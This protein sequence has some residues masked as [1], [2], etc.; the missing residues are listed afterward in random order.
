M[1]NRLPALQAEAAELHRDVRRLA[2]AQAE[3]ALAAG[4]ALVEAKALC[5]HGAWRGWLAEAGIP[6]RSARRYMRLHQA[7]LK[8][9]TVADL[10]GIRAADRF[11]AQH[12][13]PGVGME[14]LARAWMKITGGEAAAIEGWLAV[15]AALNEA[16]ALL[17]RD[18]D[19]W[20]WVKANGLDNAGGR[21]FAR[22]EIEAAMWAAGNPDQFTAAQDGWSAALAAQTMEAPR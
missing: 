9:E 6:E 14:A 16:R 22:Q 3:R 4:A 20:G 2:S 17:P 7:G 15:G 10:G 11:I 21:S 12:G 8:S 1:S 13:K 18:N 19:F 5:G